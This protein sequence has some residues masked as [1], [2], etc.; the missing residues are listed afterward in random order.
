MI[1]AMGCLT[2]TDLLIKIA[3]QTLPIGQVMI[4]YGLGSLIVFWV[5][6]RT[7]GESIRLSPLTNPTV[8]FRNI[9][10]LIALN[11][12][13]LALVYVPLSTIGAV[14]QTVPILVTVA[15]ALFLGEQVGMRRV[16]AICVGF[17]GTLLIIQPGAATFDVTAILALIAALGMALRDIATKLVRENL[18]TLML[19]FYSCFLFIISGSVLLIIKGEASLPDLD[20][21]VTVAAMIATGSMGFFFMTEAVRLGEMSVVSPFRY[22][23]L[24][25]SMAA[26]ILILG[27]QVN[28]SMIFGSALTILSGLYIWRREVVMQS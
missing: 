27:E 22:T 1:I 14:I 19:S 26:G 13:F 20:N 10:D 18:S 24:L 8:I 11:G 9:G 21:F 5:L 6:L 25:F 16:S 4:S 2:L 12:M 23:R 15:A 7:K 3:S 17:L 28:T